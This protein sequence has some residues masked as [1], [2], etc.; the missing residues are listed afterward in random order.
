MT[1]MIRYTLAIAL[2][3]CMA[4]SAEA[5]KFG[6]TNSQLILLELP[7]VKRADADLEAYQ[8]QQQK[9]FQK[10]ID[11]YKVKRTDLEKR[12]NDGTISKVEAEAELKKLAAEEQELMKHEQNMI[13]NLNQRR[14]DL[15][16]PI[17]E[18]VQKAID[19]VAEEKGYQYIFDTS[20]GVLLYAKPEDD[21]TD[22]VK[23]KLNA[24]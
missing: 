21:I 18:Q 7:A 13:A 5:Q 6:Y 19:A 10:M 11:A 4:F 23:A 24:Q 15:I 14:Q 9:Q 12:Y 2:I 8:Q 3:F 1:K 20:T 16:A 22:A 17:L